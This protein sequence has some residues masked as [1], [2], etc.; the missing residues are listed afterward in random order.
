MVE[1]GKE[2]F[3]K[4]KILIMKL[5]HFPDRVGRIIILRSIKMM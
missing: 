2:I 3:T 1:L 4:S 5:L